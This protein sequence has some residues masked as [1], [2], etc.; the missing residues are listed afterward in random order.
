MVEKNQVQTLK[1]KSMI[2]EKGIDVFRIG[3]GSL[4][5]GLNLERFIDLLEEISSRFPL[6]LYGGIFRIR[7]EAI[8]ESYAI[9]VM[10]FV[11]KYQEE[12]T[13]YYQNRHLLYF[14][15]SHVQ[16]EVKWLYG[17][18]VHSK[19]YKSIVLTSC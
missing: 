19:I 15:D 18:Q 2:A 1:F 5:A 16:L 9:V 12:Y 8:D 4:G 7:K 13:N 14:R 6:F 10:D 3:Q 17:C 11:E